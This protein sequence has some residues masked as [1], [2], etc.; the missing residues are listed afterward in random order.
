[1]SLKQG[2]K[3]KTLVITCF[4]FIL[5]KNKEQS[6]SQRPT[7]SR[8]TEQSRPFLLHVS[9]MANNILHAHYRT[10]ACGNTQCGNSVEGHNYS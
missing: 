3:L 9:L 2:R 6:S 7:A 10:F 1:M 8:Q 5:G 4:L